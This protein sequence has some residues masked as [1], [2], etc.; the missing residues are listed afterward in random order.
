MVLEGFSTESCTNYKIGMALLSCAGFAFCLIFL[1]L[2]SSFVHR[3]LLANVY[4]FE[5]DVSS[6]STLYVF[7]NSST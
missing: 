5:G 7:R 3:H 1:P 4:V 2:V 6:M